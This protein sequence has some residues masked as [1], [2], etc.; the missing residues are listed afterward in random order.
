MKKKILLLLS[1]IVSTLTIAQ[2][3]PSF[4][5]R[6]G[7]SYAGMRGDAVN[8]LQ[9]ML[10]FTGGII[11]TG[12]RTGF[13]AGTYATIRFTDNL[14]IEPALYYSQKGYELKGA[15][16]VKGMEF[17]GVNAKAKLNSQYIDIPVLIKAN[18]G[19]F[20]VFAGPQVSYLAKA[21][22]GTS[23]GVLG[24]DLLNWKTD[25]SALFNR[26]DA[27]ITGGIGYQFQNGVNVMAA[28]DHGLSK[29]DAGKS[30]AS[31]NRSFKIGVGMSF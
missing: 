6:A 12:N 11:T 31:Y 9:D 30:V 1:I 7:L 21:D 20:E 16:G 17:I 25:A 22:L 29:V 24:I 19:G 10:D 5:V 3:Q 15:L 14:S 18:L 4:G 8:N 2:V 27:G 23:A 13:F 26:W 28:Y